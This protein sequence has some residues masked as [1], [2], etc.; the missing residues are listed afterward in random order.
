VNRAPTL[1]PIADQMVVE[2][3]P[4]IISLAGI[5]A[6]AEESTQHLTISASSSD[7]DVMLTPSIVYTDG[8]STALLALVPATD[9]NGTATIT[10]TVRDDGGTIQGG[11]DAYSRTFLATMVPVNDPPIFSVPQVVDADEDQ[12]GIRIAITGIAPGPPNEVD[13]VVTLSATSSDTTIATTPRIEPG[14]VGSATVVVDLVPYRSGEVTLFVLARDDGGS[15][16]GGIDQSASPVRLVIRDINHPPGVRLGSLT[17]GWGGG[18][19]V[20]GD[21]LAFVDADAP[22]PTDLVGT[23][24]AVPRFGDLLRAGR[25]LTVGDTVTQAE[26]AAGDRIFYQHDPARGAG[27]ESFAVL[28]DDGIIAAPVGPVAVPIAIDTA[29]SGNQP[30]VFAG[31][32]IITVRDLARPWQAVATDPDGDA[33]TW[34]IVGDQPALA[35]LAWSDTATG[36]AVLTPAAG[37]TGSTTIRVGVGDGRHLPVERTLVIRVTGPDDPRPVAA[38]DPPRDA[39]TAEPY[40][41]AA[42]F[43]LGLLPGAPDLQFLLVGDVPAGMTIAKTGAATATVDW[44]VPADAV[45]GT[46]RLPGILAI[47]AVAQAATYQ[48][49]LIALRRPPAQP[50]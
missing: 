12:Q 21:L 7:P 24:T 27:A 16:H 31:G 45:S 15:E 28:L 5:T 39:I 30:P 14:P 9:A 33:L 25:V 47:D 35:S 23:L 22:P 2:D 36:A 26:L 10:V 6:G 42:R 32:T 19:A 49:L 50:N 3:Q 38:A 37:A 44:A 40:R 43:D 1:D 17:V 20:D 29:A 11:V 18:A 46:H 13:Q 48:P 4:R 34:S 8:A 41:F